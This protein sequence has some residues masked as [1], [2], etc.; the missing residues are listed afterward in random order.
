MNYGYG[1]I[2]ACKAVKKALEMAGSDVPDIECGGPITQSD[3]VNP[4]PGDT[5]PG[6]TGDTGFPT[7]PTDTGDTD[8]SAEPNDSD[9]SQE[10]PDEDQAAQTHV[11]LQEDSGCSIS[12]L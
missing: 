5:D 10:E 12:L 2:N 4:N 3:P 6:D 7:D 11:K 1:R 8:T 9:I